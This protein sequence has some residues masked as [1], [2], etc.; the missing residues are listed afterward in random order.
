MSEG[1]KKHHHL[2]SRQ[3]RSSSVALV[4]AVTY[5]DDGLHVDGLEG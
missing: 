3:V 5:R 1:Q 4:C 2:R